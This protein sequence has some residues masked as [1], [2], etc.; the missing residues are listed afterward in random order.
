MM[1]SWEILKPAA[2]LRRKPKNEGKEDSHAHVR[3]LQGIKAEERTPPH[4]STPYRGNRSGQD[5]QEIGTR[6]EVVSCDFRLSCRNLAQ[7]T[8]LAD[9]GVTQEADVS[10]DLQFQAQPPFFPRF[11]PFGKGRRPVGAG[12][13]MP[14]A[15]AAAAAFGDDGPLAVAG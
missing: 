8:R 4:R 2:R 14:V 13:E 12:A 3:G 7:D 1:I 6:R 10:Q 5:R 11:A 15:A 9:A